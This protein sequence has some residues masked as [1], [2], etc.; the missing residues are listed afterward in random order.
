[1]ADFKIGDTVRIVRPHFLNPKWARTGAIGKVVAFCSFSRD[2]CY[3]KIKGVP[4]NSNLGLFLCSG[5]LLNYTEI[6]HI[7]I[8]KYSPATLSNIPGAH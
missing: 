2:S 7:K 5:F 1:M 8:V 4:K 3:V 6:K